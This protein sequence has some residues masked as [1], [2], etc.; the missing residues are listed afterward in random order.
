MVCPE[1]RHLHDGVEFADSYNFNPHKWMGANFDCSCF[2]VRSIKPNVPRGE[3]LVHSANDL[4]QVITVRRDGLAVSL[5]GPVVAFPEVLTRLDSGYRYPIQ[6]AVN[7]FD[8]L[9]WE[10]DV[11]SEWCGVVQE[12][13]LGGRN[14][15]HYRN[16]E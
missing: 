12:L 9:Q 6:V 8:H 10:V 3:S 11:S 14:G 16:T 1:F 13:R 7:A 15:R 2:W 5:R 4:S